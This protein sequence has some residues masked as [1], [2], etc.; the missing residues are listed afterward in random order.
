MVSK[1]LPLMPILAGELFVGD[2]WGDNDVDAV[3][4]RFVDRAIPHEEFD[5][6]LGGSPLVP[7]DLQVNVHED[8]RDDDDA[9]GVF[10]RS[11]GIAVEFVRH[12]GYVAR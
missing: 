6:S 4:Q 3:L 10:D 1:T 7:C 9:V 8:L 5:R 11:V 2:K 12:C